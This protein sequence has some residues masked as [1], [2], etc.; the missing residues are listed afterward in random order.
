MDNLVHRR[1]VLT[2]AGLA[3]TASVLP[4]LSMPARPPT[5]P[6]LE[7]LEQII[8]DLKAAAQLPSLVDLLLLS[9]GQTWRRIS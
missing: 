2:G 1:N 4:A 8:T 5:D 9:F 6:R 3:L 7:A